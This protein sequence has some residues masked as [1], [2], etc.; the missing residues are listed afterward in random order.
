MKWINAVLLILAVFLCSSARAEEP[1]ITVFSFE[2][3]SCGIWTQSASEKRGRAQYDRWFRGFVSGYNFGNPANQVNLN[4]MPNED[5]LALYVDK[6]C[7]ENPLLPF[8]SAA[9]D[10]VRELREHPEQA[11]PKFERK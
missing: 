2:D 6:F 3:T 4:R 5:T 8:I 9:F 10:L 1:L 11:A 7:R